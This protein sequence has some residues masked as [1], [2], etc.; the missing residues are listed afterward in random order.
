MVETKSNSDS[1]I[2]LFVSIF[3]CPEHLSFQ[4]FSSFGIQPKAES[5]IWLNGKSE[6]TRSDKKVKKQTL[7]L[8]TDIQQNC[9]E[10]LW[11]NKSTKVSLCC[12]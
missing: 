6:N 3:I 7:E 10:H 4:E 11:D 2:S 9:S 5:S 12:L 1:P 8:S